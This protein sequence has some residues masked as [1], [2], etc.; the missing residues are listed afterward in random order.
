M[1]LCSVYP[2]RVN[3]ITRCGSENSILLRGQ[4]SRLD[5]QEGGVSTWIWFRS[6]QLLWSYSKFMPPPTSLETSGF[7]WDAPDKNGDTPQLVQWRKQC[8]GRQERWVLSL[9]LLLPGFGSLDS[10]HLSEPQFHYLWNGGNKTYLRELKWG[11]NVI[12]FNIVNVTS[13][14]YSQT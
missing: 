7:S 12:C 10:Y 14:L 9:C 11:F 5:L 2:N 13:F 8:P 6:P 1:N 3:L 4:P